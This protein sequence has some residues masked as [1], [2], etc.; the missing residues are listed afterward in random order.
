MRVQ[1]E[2]RGATAKLGDSASYFVLGGFEE[3]VLVGAAG[4]FVEG[5]SGGDHGVDAVFFFYLE[6]DEE[7]AAGGAGMCDCGGYMFAIGDV[8]AFDAVGGG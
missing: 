6:V 4:H 1:R 2:S 7:G 8:G 3:G 5:G